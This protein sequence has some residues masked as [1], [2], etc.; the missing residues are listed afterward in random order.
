MEGSQLLLI[1]D[2]DVS[3]VLDQYP[4]RDW[5]TRTGLFSSPA[6]IRKVTHGRLVKAGVAL[7]RD[8]IDISALPDQIPQ[9]RISDQSVEHS[10]DL[11]FTN[12][13]SFLYTA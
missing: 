11:Y 2:V 8:A 4:G 9:H 12:S 10:T 6:D 1:L 13:G 3:S 7:A 5:M